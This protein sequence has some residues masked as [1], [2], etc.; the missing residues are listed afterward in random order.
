MQPSS[1]LSLTLDN[2]LAPDRVATPR[3]PAGQEPIV[4]PEKLHASGAIAD[5]S[6]HRASL[7]FFPFDPV[8]DARRDR[9][10]LA[11]EL[12]ICLRF[13]GY[14]STISNSLVT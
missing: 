5:Q 2:E 1:P 7:N 6:C 4:T 8:R 11:L 13:G 12:E 9:A 14:L 10:H 3:P